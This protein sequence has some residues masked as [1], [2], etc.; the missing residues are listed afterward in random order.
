MR[1]DNLS[2]HQFESDHKRSDTAWYSIDQ[3]QT[4]AKGG[5]VIPSLRTKLPGC[6]MYQCHV[7]L[8]ESIVLRL[9]VQV[10]VADRGSDGNSAVI[11]SHPTSRRAATEKAE[12]AEDAHHRIAL[13]QVLEM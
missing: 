6:C 2:E 9:S 11:P 5:V 3:P 8:V 10:R 7:Q 13:Q 12:S 4:C 1:Q